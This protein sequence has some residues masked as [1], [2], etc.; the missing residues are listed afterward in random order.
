MPDRW[1][2]WVASAS[3]AWRRSAR[4]CAPARFR[5]RKTARRLAA[6]VRAVDAAVTACGDRDV[7]AVWRRFRIVGNPLQPLVRPGTHALDRDASLR[8]AAA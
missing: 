8:H 4:G 7:A 6:L 3:R 5:E 1:R 2:R